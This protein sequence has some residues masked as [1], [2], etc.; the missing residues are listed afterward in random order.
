M[1]V[2]ILSSLSLAHKHSKMILKTSS[3]RGQSAYLLLLLPPP[4]LLSPSYIEKEKEERGR[5]ERMMFKP[6]K[7]LIKPPPQDNLKMFFYLFKALSYTHTQHI[8]SHRPPHPYYK[9]VS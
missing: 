5:R 4:P 8:A 9:L 2:L 7:R 1:V 6:T 3:F